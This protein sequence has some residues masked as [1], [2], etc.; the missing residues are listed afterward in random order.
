MKLMQVL[1]II[2][3]SLSFISIL[4]GYLYW[5]LYDQILSGGDDAILF[6]ILPLLILLSSLIYLIFSITFLFKKKEEN[7]FVKFACW[8]NIVVGILALIVIAYAFLTARD[9]SFYWLLYVNFPLYFFISSPI[10]FISF[11]LFLI[12]FFKSHKKI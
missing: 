3:I 2:F 7:G 9:H 1:N 10:T 5:G 4:F 6:G 11:I 12:G 8:I